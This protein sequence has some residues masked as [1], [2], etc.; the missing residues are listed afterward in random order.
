MLPRVLLLPGR[1][2]VLRA[3]RVPRLER[4]PGAEQRAQGRDTG[5]AVRAARA[6]AA[7]RRRHRLQQGVRGDSGGG[8]DRRARVRVLAASGQ[9]GQEPVPEHHRM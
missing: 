5:A 7:R 9:Q 4:A 8:D 1:S 2:A 6:G 3:D